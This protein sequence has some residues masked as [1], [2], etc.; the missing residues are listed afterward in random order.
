VRAPRFNPASKFAGD[1][2]FDEHGKPKPAVQRAVERAI[3]VQR[4]LVLANIRRLR[5]KHPDA[6]A[7]I[8]AA[9]LERDYLAA[10]TAG[11]AAVGATAAVPAVGTVASLG[12]SAAATVGFLEATALYA[13]SVAELHGIETDEPERARTM[14]MGILLGEEGTALIQ[15][16]LGASAGRSVNSHWGNVVGKS[17]PMSTVRTVGSSIRKK[18]LRR[19]LARQSG[20]LLG[21]ALPFGVGAAVGGVGNHMMGRTVIAATR[22]AFGP[23]PEVIPGELLED[24]AS[25]PVA[26]TDGS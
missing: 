12:L 5:K 11:G 20:A 8:L 10:V 4:P 6:D 16:V 15:S 1:A 7:A 24:L 25:L 23:P 3:D 26:E 17:I 22:E 9:K 2:V 21:R 14:V 19:I 18:F 13:Q